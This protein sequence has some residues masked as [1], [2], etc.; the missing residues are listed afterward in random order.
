MMNPVRDEA[1]DQ[2]G[3]DEHQTV[4]DDQ[5]R[6][7]GPSFASSSRFWR[8]GDTVTST[9]IPRKAPAAPIYRPSTGLNRAMLRP[10]ATGTSRASPTRASVDRM[11]PNPR[12]TN[13]LRPTR[14][15]AVLAAAIDR[16]VRD[17]RVGEI[18]RPCAGSDAEAPNRLDGQR[19]EITARAPTEI[20]RQPQ[21]HAPG[22]DFR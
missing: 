8:I 2:Q 16:I 1:R 9:V 19:D 15:R 3:H 18:A 11:P 12:R 14:R 5:S 6:F 4:S 17:R 13:R 10:A 22:P 21:S 20:E 7:H